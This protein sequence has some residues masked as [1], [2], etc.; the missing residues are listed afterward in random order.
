MPKVYEFNTKKVHVNKNKIN[1]PTQE[2]RLI[3]EI[4]HTIV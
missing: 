1:A 2:N 3:F 4:F